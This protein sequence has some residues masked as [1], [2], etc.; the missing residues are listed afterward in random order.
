LTF[1][2]EGVLQRCQVGVLCPYD[3]IIGVFI[4]YMQY[5]VYKCVYCCMCIYMLPIYVLPFALE[6]VLQRCQ[7][8]VC[9]YKTHTHIKPNSNSVFLTYSHI[10]IQHMCLLY[11]RRW[12]AP[13]PLMYVT[14]ITIIDTIIHHILTKYTNDAYTYDI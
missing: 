14:C 13:G 1:A 12:T 2:L 4:V 8:G 10:C 3:I 7:V 6:G 11:T 5:M 9:V